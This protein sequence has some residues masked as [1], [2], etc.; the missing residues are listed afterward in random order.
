M[1]CYGNS[2]GK[3]GQGTRVREHENVLEVKK[4]PSSAMGFVMKDEEKQYSIGIL[5]EVIIQWQTD[6][7]S[8]APEGEIK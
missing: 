6:E 3:N 5:Q 4:Y 7:L 1:K 2:S 8:Y